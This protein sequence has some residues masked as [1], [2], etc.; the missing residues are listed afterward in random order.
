MSNTSDLTVGFVYSA[1]MTSHFHPQ[2]HPEQPE[3]ISS[4]WNAIV[5]AHYTS[6]MKR[7]PIR[8]VEKHEALIVHSE[9][10]WNKV[11]AI[12]RT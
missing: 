12:Q 7:L 1:S 2:G 5:D 3:R 4:I 8:E 9:D 11:Q 6:K 10:H